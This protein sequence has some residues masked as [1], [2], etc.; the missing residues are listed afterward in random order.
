MGGEICVHDLDIFHYY[1][2]FICVFFLNEDFLKG[3]K[4]LLLLF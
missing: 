1:D 3:I 4:L 2:N